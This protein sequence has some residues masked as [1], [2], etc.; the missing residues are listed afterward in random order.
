[1]NVKLKR[2]F[3]LT[4]TLAFLTACM[5][6][7]ALA[8]EENVFEQEITEVQPSDNQEIQT[9]NNEDLELDIPETDEEPAEESTEEPVE[10]STE[11][12]VEETVQEPAQEPEQFRVFEDMFTNQG[13]ALDG[14]T[15]TLMSL[16]LSGQ[17]NVIYENNF[18]GTSTD[19]SE[20]RETGITSLSRDPADP[21][22]TDKQV[23]KITSMGTTPTSS[24]DLT[25]FNVNI[26]STGRRY[27]ELGYDSEK[28]VIYEMDIYIP[29]STIKTNGV[30][31]AGYNGL[32]VSPHYSSNNSTYYKNK[33]IGHGALT[34]GINGAEGNS[35]IPTGQFAINENI[36]GTTTGKRATT[37][38]WHTF[39]WAIS[40]GGTIVNMWVDDTRI[41]ENR[42]TKRTLTST[43]YM[44]GI[45]ITGTYHSTSPTA[46]PEGTSIYVDNVK[47]YQ[48]TTQT[49]SF[50][51]ADTT[52]VDMEAGIVVDLKHQLPLA[53]LANY[54]SI[55]RG[56]EII[57]PTVSAVQGEPTKVRIS[58][59]ELEGAATY[60]VYFDGYACFTSADSLEITTK[61]PTSMSV[62]A[63][64]A[65]G[66]TLPAGE[67]TVTLTFSQKIAASDVEQK[68]TIVDEDGNDQSFTV[69]QDGEKA[70]KVSM[71][72][73]ELCDYTIT[74]DQSI[75]SNDNL[76]LPLIA[77]FVL[78]VGTEAAVVVPEEDPYGNP[79][80]GDTEP[81]TPAVGA[82][83]SSWYISDAQTGA[84]EG[85]T[86]G[87]KI[88]VTNSDASVSAIPKATSA[89]SYY[90]S[91]NSAYP[92]ASVLVYEYDLKLP[93]L[94]NAAQSFSTTYNF[95]ITSDNS[96]D[97]I[98]ANV[99][100]D[101]TPIT[102][103]YDSNGITL[104]KTS[105]SS[106][107]T[108]L[109]T[110]DELSG[111]SDIHIKFTIDNETGIATF[112]RSDGVT[113][114]I[115][116]TTPPN[117][118]D[119]A[120][121]RVWSPYMHI[122]NVIFYCKAQR[123]QTAEFEVTNFSVK[124]ITKSL[125][126][127]GA[128]FE[129][130][131]YYVDTQNITISFNDD[132]DIEKLK[133]A[134]YVTDENGD[135]VENCTITVTGADSDF[136]VSITG[137]SPYT[138]YNLNIEGLIAENDRIMSE[139]FT[140][141]FV[142]KKSSPVFVDTVDAAAVLN[143]HGKRLQKATNIDYTLVLK[144]DGGTVENYIG[145]VAVYDQND[146][147][148]KI[149]Y[150]DI[151]VGNNLFTLTGVPLGAAR[152]RA[153]AWKKNTDGSLGA[154]LHESDL[155]KEDTQKPEY[156]LEYKN[157][158]PSFEGKITDAV[159]SVMSISGK[160]TD[161]DGVY[162]LLILDG[163]DT[164]LTQAA[165]KT[166]ALVSANVTATGTEYI[167]GNTFAF[168][169]PTGTYTAYVVTK[170]G[171]YSND[172][173]YIVLSELINEYVIPLSNGTIAQ[174]QIL[175][176]TLEYNAAIG[177]DFTR[178]FV[179][180]RDKALFQKRMYEKRT[181]LVGPTDNDYIN[182]L[183]TNIDYARREI[184]YLNELKAISYA[185]LIADKLRNG[186]EF[187][188]M[189]F[190]AYD[191]SLTDTQR[192]AVCSNILGKTFADGDAL[193]TEFDRLVANPPVTQN[194]VVNDSRNDGPSG[195]TSMSQNLI[196][197]PTP[198][199][200]D[201][202]FADLSGYDWAKESIL[203]LAQKGIINGV[204]NGEFNPSGL[205]TRE[206]F[207]KMI[208]L[209]LDSFDESEITDFSDVD[210]SQWYAPYVASAQA[211]GIVNGISDTE[212]GVG[213]HITRQDMAVVIYRALKANGYTFT[214]EKKEFADA[215]Q[216]KDYSLEAVG[217]LAAEG[218]LNGV[219]DN[220]FAPNRN[221]TRA[222]AAKLI[223]A[224][225]KLC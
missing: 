44:D 217:I 35:T 107:S 80:H 79:V 106:S 62:S 31:N 162:T 216:I 41:V 98:W 132:I 151:T 57:T 92:H 40:A 197:A 127:D 157:T 30:N 214:T 102:F 177:I 76:A 103:T 29:E 12:P 120:S 196:S 125:G 174:N 55:E 182:Q 113:R 150:Q 112:F 105:V 47:I 154:L 165:T 88:S 198:V 155:I 78:N 152:I 16:V 68:L 131:D 203:S 170:N 158:L 173:E 189:V 67:N 72:L 25:S 48:I 59:T 136:G 180:D 3:C 187:T 110:A 172:F 121:N 73:G 206:Q 51:V 138:R 137:L 87:V 18:S 195:T 27:S 99:G 82:T 218:I 70:V 134:I 52:N 167:Y 202:V 209:V 96:S 9:D 60:T 130:G 19:V 42:A 64:V 54:F 135:K 24:E 101:G 86:D 122:R 225:D 153:Y 116:M 201:Q 123:R 21:G 222:E 94:E 20:C 118:G 90:E 142:T 2:I 104:Q 81:V 145:A 147:L 220:M 74:L 117:W 14:E 10:E 207:A 193:K 212:F 6:T 109:Y 61:A 34:M 114:T 97:P 63:D 4:L 166:L 119:T 204:G 178:E 38:A 224:L 85:I 45:K 33:T 46:F 23:L 175:T 83:A 111:V 183:V 39:K 89:E 148:L 91:R 200:P 17:S 75:T 71:N 199:T 188:N 223:E 185:G 219:G 179:S 139:K 53:D 126:V 108:K 129:H 8:E 28:P 149:S 221:A 171:A 184:A 43:S 11:E 159:N 65:E 128:S 69:A 160:T 163:E 100:K 56:D 115:D 156:T 84:I 133:K 77:D 143:T 164:P 146:G 15:P 32:Y 213:M 22:N 37:D 194:T 49:P 95:G 190:T 168:N 7:L 93:D 58:S 5:P 211:S 181:L 144:N 1:M 215:D 50:E 36:N 26:K 141:G 191:G 210:A 169:S 186:T 124:R 140:R 192:A 66:T 161:T 205:V 13:M 208:V 176:K